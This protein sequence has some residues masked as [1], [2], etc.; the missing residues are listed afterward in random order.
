MRRKKMDSK[1]R[2]ILLGAIALIVLIIIIYVG[3]LLFFAKP[4]VS[5]GLIPS[6]K[7][8]EEQVYDS[9][10]NSCNSC[11]QNCKDN[12]LL[13][14]SMVKKDDSLCS[15]I[16]NEF[17]K[18]ECEDNFVFA[19]AVEK[20]DTSYCDKLLDENKGAGCIYSVV[21]AKAVE[22]NDVLVCDEL[23]TSRNSCKD[24]FYLR[25]NQCEL[26]TNSE[27]KN[28]CSAQV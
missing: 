22:K 19:M 24:N 4:N 15:E 17:V 25:T 20:M 13:E 10:L 12:F 23:E 27:L 26:I 2:N 6:D 16:K 8:F 1:W 18:K 14:N 9:C 7:T 11:E 5:D 28:E 21:L 3:Y